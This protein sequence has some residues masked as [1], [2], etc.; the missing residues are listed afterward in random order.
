MLMQ[1][2]GFVLFSSHTLPWILLLL[3]ALDAILFKTGL[4]SLRL[5]N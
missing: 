2:T 5:R 3:A 4:R 1:S